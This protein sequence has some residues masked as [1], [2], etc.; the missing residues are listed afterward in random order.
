MN[1]AIKVT[2]VAAIKSGNKRDKFLSAESN[3]LK[4]GNKKR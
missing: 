1:I 3:L 2:N 4:Y